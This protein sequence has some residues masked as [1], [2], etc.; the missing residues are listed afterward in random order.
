MAKARGT[1]AY[2]IGLIVSIVLTIILGV[3]TFI[4]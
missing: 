1:T 4:F 3:T 2:Q